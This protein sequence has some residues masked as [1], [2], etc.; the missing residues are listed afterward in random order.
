MVLG[1]PVAAKAGAAGGLA[2]AFVVGC[3]QLAALA[4]R[5]GLVGL[6]ELEVG[7]GGVEEQQIDFEVQQARDLMEDL[8][9]EG[10]LDLEEP[11]HGPVAGVVA[12]LRQAR[13]VHVL[14][15][16]ARG[17]QLVGRGQS[18]VGDQREEHAL[19]GRIAAPA[20]EQAAHERVDPQ[21]PPKSVEGVAAA[22]GPRVEEVEALAG[23]GH[24]GVRLEE[25]R[26]RAREALECRPAMRVL[27]TE[28]VDHLGPRALR[29][30]VPGVVRKLQ[31]ADDRAVLVAPWCGTHI[32]GLDDLTD[33]TAEQELSHETC[34]YDN[35]GF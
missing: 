9:L 27:A 17:G 15:Y 25:A 24:S 28:V 23:G 31:V 18:T 12:G 11:I 2:L 29:H 21:A 30:G 13:D 19:G 34:I 16:P 8:A 5:H 6:V 20:A 3:R 4:A 33:T 22:Q 14:A 1:A 32:H 35:P 26:E 10:A 7:R